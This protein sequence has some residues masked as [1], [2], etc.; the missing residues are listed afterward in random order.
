LDGTKI[1]EIISKLF[2]EQKYLEKWK[3]KIR[4]ER[5]EILKLVC[6]GEVRDTSIYRWTPPSYDGI[7][8][9]MREEFGRPSHPSAFCNY[10][11]SKSITSILIGFNDF[12]IP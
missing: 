10:K 3:E 8:L 12:A 9:K 7:V 4:K 6:F 1:L 2:G 11:H 5:R